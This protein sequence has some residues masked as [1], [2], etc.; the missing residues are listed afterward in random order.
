M[1]KIKITPPEGFEIDKEKS[2]FEEIVFKPIQKVDLSILNATDWF[3]IESTSM[4]YNSPVYKKYVKGG[5]ILRK[6]PL[7]EGWVVDLN[8]EKNNF[9]NCP[10][11]SGFYLAETPEHIVALRKCTE[12]EIAYIKKNKPEWFRKTKWEDFG[13]NI[14][15]YYDT[16]PYL[17][18]PNSNSKCL[19]PTSELAGASRA[20]CQLVRFRDDWN[21]G[22]V[23]DWEDNSGKYKITNHKNKIGVYCSYS[24]SRILAFKDRDTATLFLET[25]KDLIEIAKPLL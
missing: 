1:E 9:Y 18:V 4:Y 5:R 22:W 6:D 23:P 8:I 2:T 17:P 25:F 21:E 24:I 7:R 11:Y 10:S 15:G 20:L 12:E 19:W 13:N 14:Q 16:Y 3:Y